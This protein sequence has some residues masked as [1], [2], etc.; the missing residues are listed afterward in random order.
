MRLEVKSE[1]AGRIWKILANVGQAVAEDEQFI[2]I[3]SMKMEIP[4]VAPKKGVIREIRVDE[5]NEISEGQI[6]AVIT[7]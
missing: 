1:I 6:L 4:V 3:E 5:G 7:D 2:I